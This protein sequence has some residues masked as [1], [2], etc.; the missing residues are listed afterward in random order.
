MRQVNLT[1]L[2]NAIETAPAPF[3][4]WQPE[5]CGDIDIEIR[6]NGDWFF[7]GS[8]ISRLPLV[9]LFASVLVYQD[10]Q[11]YLKTPI[12]KMR[13]RVKDAPFLI[14]EWYYK[15]SFMICRD[16]LG[17]DYILSKNHTILV[18]N[19]IPYLTLHNGLLAKVTRNV[20]YQWA[21]I[22]KESDGR[23]SISSGDHTFNIG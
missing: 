13:I 16:N 3:D 7:H 19:D 1:E 6:E 9:K 20:F 17:R 22:A 12:E 10:E 2:T 21:E 8:K 15:E 4:K 11:F 18:K 5:L 23:F 14:T